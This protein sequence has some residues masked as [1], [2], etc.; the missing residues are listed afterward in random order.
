MRY[1]ITIKNADISQSRI[2]SDTIEAESPEGA[3]QMA[4]TRMQ[5]HDQAN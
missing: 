5:Y 1:L 2:W 3:L 4:V